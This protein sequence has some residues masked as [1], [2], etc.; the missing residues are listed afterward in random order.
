MSRIFG[1]IRQNGY[2]VRDIEVAMRHWAEV[3]GVGPWFY[4]ERIPLLDYQYKGKPGVL[5]CA[6]ALTNSG[7]L[8]V[9]LVQPR[10]AGPSLFHDFLAAGHEG[11]QHIAYWT[12]TFDADRARAL[13]LGYKIG[14]EGS[15][16]K[17]GPFAYFLTEAHPGT[18]VELSS[19]VGLKKK[20]FDHIAAA[21]RGWDG[22]DPIR[23]F[24]KLD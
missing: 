5:E 22:R 17:Y 13:A 21:A 7:P 1:A 14:Q 11:L 8:Q 6:V 23:A 9:E 12:E 19:V 4:A 10:T 2:V 20:L 24:P 3:I 16:G 15:T 18:V